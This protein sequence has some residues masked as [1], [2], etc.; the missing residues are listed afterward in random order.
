[1]TKVQYCLPTFM[2]SE[3]KMHSQH[4]KKVLPSIN[5]ETFIQH[6]GVCAPFA[7]TVLISGDK[8]TPSNM[9]RQVSLRHLECL[10]G[11]SEQTWPHITHRQA[12]CSVYL[13]ICHT[14]DTR[15]R[16]SHHYF[17]SSYYA[18][19]YS[20]KKGNFAVSLLRM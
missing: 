9:Y 12:S 17:K 18:P 1:M 14:I 7:V 6:V 20:P 8:R 11:R 4:N 5:A 2:Y 19:T 16:P 3:C 10:N 13:S 15:S